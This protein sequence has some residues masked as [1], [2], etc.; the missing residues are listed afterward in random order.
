MKKKKSKGSTFSKV[1]KP[2][3]SKDKV[4]LYGEGVQPPLIE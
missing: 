2:S 4:M 3:K 1:N